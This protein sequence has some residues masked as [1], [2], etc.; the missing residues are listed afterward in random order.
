[1]SVR[2]LL[3]DDHK[4]FR[5]GLAALLEG[6]S[7]WEL[8]AEASNGEEALAL[9]GRS[10][11]DVIILDLQMPKLNGLDVAQRIREQSPET[12]VVVLSSYSDRQCIERALAVGVRGYVLTSEAVDDLIEAVKAALDDRQFLSPTLS[13]MPASE[14][15]RSPQIDKDS[16]SAREQDVLRLLCEGCRTKEIA[17]RLD[18]SARTIETYRSLLTQ[19]LGIKSLSGLVKIAL[20][21]GI[22]DILGDDPEPGRSD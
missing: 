8:V 17:T 22:A 11:T 15:R 10:Q 9:T 4:L 3:A 2:I 5:Q 1:L 21:T 18:I 14:E 6:A 20:R 7:D 13:A 12:R 19:K 16:L